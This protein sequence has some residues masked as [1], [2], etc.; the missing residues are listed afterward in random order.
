MLGRVTWVSPSYI[1]TKP[2]VVP[3]DHELDNAT[4]TDPEV[5]RPER[6][7]EQPEAPIF[8]FGVGSRMCVGMQLAYRELYILFLRLLSSYEIKPDGFIENH[9]IRGVANPSS[10][11]TQPKSY[12][13]KFVPRNLR[14]LQ[15]ALEGDLGR[16]V[17]EQKA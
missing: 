14:A 2:S 9:P 8:T 7:L 13:V 1:E 4:W 17:P 16:K 3:D 11:T 15:M 12:K 6:W 5:F 10:L